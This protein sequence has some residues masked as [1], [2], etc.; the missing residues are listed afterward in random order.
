MY[1]I[2][3]VI[4]KKTGNE[5]MSQ[6]ST[7]LAISIPTYNRAKI[8]DS[9]LGSLV[10]LLE[11]YSIPIYISDNASTD[12]TETIVR[13]WIARYPHI[14][15]SKNEINMGMSYNIIHALTLP[16]TDYVWLLSDDD[17]LMAS[18]I[19]TVLTSLDDNFDLIVVNAKT[20]AESNDL[21]VNDLPNK[22]YTE[23]KSFIEEL[24][25]HITFISCLI[26][27]R[28]FVDSSLYS[29]YIKS[30]FP[31]TAALLEA[32]T[33]KKPKIKWISTAQIFP[34]GNASDFTKNPTFLEIFVKDWSEVINSLPHYAFESKEKC[35]LMHGEKAE[36]FTLKGFCR[37]RLNGVLNFNSYKKYKNIFHKATKTPN[38]NILFVSIIPCKL[39]YL[40]KKFS[41]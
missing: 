8:L 26:V 10:P 35:I 6:I 11:K 17:R 16:Q 33:L 39:L 24:G 12:S 19:E 25:W 28:D 23:E 9:Q 5:I 18:S 30:F 36:I 22:I 38:I 27:R 21:R 29:K 7:K 3:N 41:K 15:F 20:T 1:S 34:N 40:I 2:K 4:V 13:K 14:I 31:H 32:A 37:L